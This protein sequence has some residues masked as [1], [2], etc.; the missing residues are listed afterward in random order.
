M[1]SL[2]AAVASV[3]AAL[4][5]RE[6]LQAFGTF[7]IVNRNIVIKPAQIVANFGHLANRIPGL[8]GFANIPLGQL[9][10]G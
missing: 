10:N 1:A 2:S 6:I 7:T 4:V 3:A 9:T 8:F 5:I